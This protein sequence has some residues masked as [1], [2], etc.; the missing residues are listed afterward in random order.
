MCESLPKVAIHAWSTLPW[1]IFCISVSCSCSQRVNQVSFSHVLPACVWFSVCLP[2]FVC[3]CA[4]VLVCLP[5]ACVKRPVARWGEAWDHVLCAS[6][7]VSLFPARSQ[8][9]RQTICTS[10]RVCRKQKKKKEGNYCFQPTPASSG[11]ARAEKVSFILFCQE[12]CGPAFKVGM[13][14]S[15]IF[16]CRS[17]RLTRQSC[18]LHLWKAV[19]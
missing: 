13:A 16:G 8:L 3:L 5:H 6:N 12:F 18:L 4:C 14:L 2:V 10:R 17:S 15:L 9:Y 11:P 7:F 1:L 19:N